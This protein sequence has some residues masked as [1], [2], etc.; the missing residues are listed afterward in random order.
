[1]AIIPGWEN[2][3]KDTQTALIMSGAATAAGVVNTLYDNKRAEEDREERAIGNRAE[4]INE[5]A[6][7]EREDYQFGQNQG[8]DR[9]VAASQMSGTSPLQHQSQRAQMSATGDFLSGKG[10]S[11]LSTNPAAAGVPSQFAKHMPAGGIATTPFSSSTL[12]FFSPE[13]MANAEKNYWAAQQ[14]IDPRLAGPDLGKVGYGGAG[15]EVSGDLET[16]RQGRLE[17]DAAA[18]SA[19]EEQARARREALLAAL[20]ELGPTG[21]NGNEDDNEGIDWKKWGMTGAGLGAAYLGG[22]YA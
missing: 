14:N 7:G 19:Y 6:R 4:G 16:Q 12:N 15:A 8:D 11:T 13:S 18:S 2:L 22:R 17:S 3:S 1:M 21:Q 20:A 9:A 5:V 10:R